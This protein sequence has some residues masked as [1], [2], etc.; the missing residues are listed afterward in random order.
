MPFN[1]L[2]L[3]RMG[4]ILDPLRVLLQGSVAENR[5]FDQI[6]A[7]MEQRDL[8]FTTLGVGRW[9]P[10]TPVLTAN[11]TN[12]TLGTGSSATGSWTRFGRTVI[13]SARIAFGTGGGA[14]AG[15]GIYRITLPTTRQ[16]TSPYDLNTPCGSGTMLDNTGFDRRIVIPHLDSVTDTSVVLLYE[17][18]VGV[19]TN[20][21]PWTWAAGDHIVI[22]F[23]YDGE[24]V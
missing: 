10:Y 21:A 19:V 16:R 20:A 3:P 8:L 17:A 4:A 15:S 7:R 14:A 12:P 5:M 13:G 11:P 9:L 1:G 22:N 6:V 24:F 2:D 23:M 18:A